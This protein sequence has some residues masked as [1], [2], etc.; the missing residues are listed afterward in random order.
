[1][2]LGHEEQVCQIE[3]QPQA[4]GIIYLPSQHSLT[5]VVWEELNKELF[6]EEK[7]ADDDG[8]IPGPSRIY[9]EMQNLREDEQQQQ[10]QQQLPSVNEEGSVM[11]TPALPAM[12]QQQQLPTV[13]EEGSV[14][15]APALPD[16]QQQQMDWN[17]IH[18]DPCLPEFF[19]EMDGVDGNK[20]NIEPQKAEDTS[21][22]FEWL[23]D[24]IRDMEPRENLTDLTETT[25]L[26]LLDFV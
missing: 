2:F 22:D 14:M 8:E 7:N 10:Q 4:D 19:M 6:N 26:S 11:L 1:M 5:Q 17:G 3:E 20:E 9:T 12:Q 13:N 25:G 16:M 21:I 18:Y 23:D 24:Y 15:L